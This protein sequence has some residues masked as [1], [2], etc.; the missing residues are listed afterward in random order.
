MHPLHALSQPSPYVA[1][2]WQ[3]EQGLPQ[4]SVY[5]I[6]PDD[7]GYLWLVTAAGIARFD[8]V[9]L[10][11]FSVAD[12]DALRSDW[13]MILPESR[14]GDLW[15]GTLHSG[16]Y[17]FRDGKARATEGGSSVARDRDAGIWVS[18]EGSLQ[19]ETGAGAEG[20][21]TLPD[22]IAYSTAARRYKFQLFRN[23]KVKS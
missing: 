4:N 11:V 18:G 7:D 21:L 3:T 1:T 2:N 5:D 9:R 16:L 22:R 10:R 17:R 14:S 23:N 8:G 15:I 6:V 12:V 19:C 20:E 13:M